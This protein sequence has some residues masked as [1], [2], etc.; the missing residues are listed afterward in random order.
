MPP[1]GNE[2]ASGSPWESWDPE[3]FSSTRSSPGSWAFKSMK[4]SCF[5]AVS[6]VIGWNQWVK[7]VAPSEMAQS[8]ATEAMASATWRSRPL[9]WRRVDSSA[10]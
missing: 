3:T 1:E 8:R 6:P 9:P 7:W 5:S 10:S 2:L 4:L